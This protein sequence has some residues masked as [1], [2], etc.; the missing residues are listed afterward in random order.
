MNTRDEIF[1]QVLVRNNRT[2]TDG[3]I[4][5]TNLKTWY[6]DAYLWAAGYHKWPFTEARDA[7][8]T[9]SGTETKPYSEFDVEF[10]SDSIRLLLIDGK[11]FKKIGFESYLT[12]RE[13]F[14]DSTDRVF[15][16]FGRTLYINPNADVSGTI[17]AYGQEQPAID[18]TDETGT[19]VFSTYDAEGNEAIYEKMSSF[20][21]RRE[22]LI[23][24]AEIHDQRASA[25]LEEVWKKVLDEQY[26]YQESP[27]S[28][29]MFERFDVLR[30]RGIEDLR[31]ENQF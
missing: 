11:R 30:G 25:K 23:D 17:A 29:G 18:V 20:L 14:P 26:K 10:K 16:D 24:E 5:E 27:T 8:D 31:N 21:K 19:T 7:S 15:S 22:H 6:R 12:F 9:W 28:E 13:E 1:T 3:F 4:T 2:T